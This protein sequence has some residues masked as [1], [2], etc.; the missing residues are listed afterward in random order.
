MCASKSSSSSCNRSS[1]RSVIFP[2]VSRFLSTQLLPR[3]ED[4]SGGVWI[5][6]SGCFVFSSTLARINQL[7]FFFPSRLFND[8]RACRRRASAVVYLRPRTKAA[9]N[10][11]VA[12]TFPVFSF[13]SDVILLSVEIHDT[14]RETS[15]QSG[16]FQP[17]V[18]YT[19]FSR[20]SQ[21]LRFFSTRRVES[22]WT[23]YKLEDSNFSLDEK[24]SKERRISTIGICLREERFTRE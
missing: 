14:T 6:F 20:S 22:K 10:L 23:L 13:P 4:G 12:H 19:L 2:S 3:G 11:R 15:F 1:H 21:G 16:E 9:R 17:C 5:R 18:Y 8:E 7:S 24:S